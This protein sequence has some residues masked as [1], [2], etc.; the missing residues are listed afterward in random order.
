MSDLKL[1]ESFR[2]SS[3]SV[4]ADP[5]GGSGRGLGFLVYLKQHTS[6]DCMWKQIRESSCL[7]LSQTLKVFA[8][9]VTLLNISSFEKV[10][11][12]KNTYVT[13]K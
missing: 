8:E 3:Q 6:V 1:E 7:Q 4:Q 13:R 12:L 5:F 10:T 11:F 9:C 2:K